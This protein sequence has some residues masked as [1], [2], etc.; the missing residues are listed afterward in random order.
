M[1]QRRRRL[2]A[3]NWKMNPASFAEAYTLAT[4]VRESIGI[5]EGVDVVVCPPAIWLSGVRDA[6]R[7]SAIDVGAQTMHWEATGAFTGET[8]P[9]ML[10]GDRSSP[11]ATHVIIGHSER[12]QFD[13]ETDEK[14]A[15]KVAAAFDWGLVPILAIGETLGQ[16]QAGDA[17][18]VIETQLRAGIGGVSAIEGR[19]LAIA[20]E[21][22]WAIGTGVAASP[23]DA[24]AAGRLIR[25]ILRERFPDDA[26]RVPILYG[27]SVTEANA[28]EFLE[29]PDVDGALVGGAS[30]KPDVFAAIVE[31]AAASVG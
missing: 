10:G 20:Y 21:P 22:V 3:G 12:R 25:A 8:S 27:G 24:E 6:L 23:S 4:L 13:G 19:R 17:E 26:D 5:A 18:R 28:G 11:V 29:R 9:A 14:V 16:R 7:G 15:R 31:A 30:L 2:I 1:A